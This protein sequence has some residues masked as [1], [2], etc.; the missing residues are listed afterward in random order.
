MM[1]L[2]RELPAPGQFGPAGGVRLLASERVGTVDRDLYAIEA[3]PLAGW[4]LA[5][6]RRDDGSISQIH[7][8]NRPYLRVNMRRIAAAGGVR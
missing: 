1:S 8:P 2:G 7:V 6:D 3:G 4:F 5:V